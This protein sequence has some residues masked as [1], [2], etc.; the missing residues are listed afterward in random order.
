M[1]IIINPG[2][3]PVEGATYANAKANMDAFAADANCYA[4]TE[5]ENPDMGD[6][7]FKFLVCNRSAGSEDGWHEIEM[8]GLPLAQVRYMGDE[9]QNIWDFP[10]LYVDDASWVWKYAIRAVTEHDDQD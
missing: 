6:G 5:V 9:G 4:P 7:R 1:T 2:T 3:G 10:R 8:P